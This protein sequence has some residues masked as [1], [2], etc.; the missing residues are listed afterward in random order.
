MNY[1]FTGSNL[2]LFGVRVINVV[3]C[4]GVTLFTAN[5]ALVFLQVVFWC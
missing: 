4:L 2:V 1:A 3:L 5:G